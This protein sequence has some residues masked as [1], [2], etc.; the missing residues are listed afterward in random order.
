M[1]INENKVVFTTEESF[2]YSE[3][4]EKYQLWEFHVEARSTF[5][6]YVGR[7]FSQLSYAIVLLV[8]LCVPKIEPR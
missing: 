3:G 7:L 2:H 6:I 4:L 8:N 5:M 1:K